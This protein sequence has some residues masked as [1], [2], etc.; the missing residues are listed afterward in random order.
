ML[1]GNAVGPIDEALAIY[2]GE[3][4]SDDEAVAFLLADLRCWCAENGVNFDAALSESRK[5][6]AA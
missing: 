3:E 6:M 5:Q 4:T 2:Q 1:D